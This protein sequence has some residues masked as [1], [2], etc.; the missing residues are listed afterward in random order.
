MAMKLRF[1]NAVQLTSGVWQIPF[2]EDEKR[3]FGPPPVAGAAHGVLV[4]K[5][6][7]FS[8]AERTLSID[9]TEVRWIVNG[10]SE[11]ALILGEETMIASS[12]ETEKERKSP[13]PEESIGRFL[14]S[15]RFHQ[16]P[17]ELVQA[18]G[19][20][21][22]EA[23]DRNRFKLE[24]GSNRKWTA[25]PNFVALTIQNRN[26]KLLVSVKGNPKDMKYETIFPKVSRPPYCEFH[27]EDPAQLRDVKAATWESILR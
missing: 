10:S 15:C 11:K 2:L 18:A 7:S 14:A 4:A 24:E 6:P 25:T 5:S 27:F 9:P 20:L 3:F 21:L 19:E 13:F 1:D 23:F 17:E 12:V 16:L 8:A 26:R 22:V